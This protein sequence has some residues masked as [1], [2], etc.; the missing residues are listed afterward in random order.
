MAKSS[1]RVVEKSDTCVEIKCPKPETA[2]RYMANISDGET[3]K[4]VM[5]DYYW[6]VQAEMDCTVASGCD[7]VVYCP[8]LEKPMHIVRIE[9]NDE[10]ILQIHERISLAEKYI[11]E[12]IIKNKNTDKDNGNNRSCEVG[13]ADTKRD[14]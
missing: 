5:P 7:F 4:E 8:F 6:Q 10:A 12:H 3:Q 13:D 11:T 14:K 9:R 1:T 2:V